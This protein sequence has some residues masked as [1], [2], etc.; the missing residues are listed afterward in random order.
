MEFSEPTLAIDRTS[1]RAAV[2]QMMTEFVPTHFLTF[3]FNSDVSVASADAELR[4]FKQWL[5]RAMTGKRNCDGSALEHIATI[6]H[7]ATNLHIHA[8]F[9]VPNEW[10]QRFEQQAPRVWEKLRN[11]GSL[12]I[13]SVYSAAGVADYITKEM[14]P[15]ASHRLLV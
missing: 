4:K 3:A 9:R 7:E 8:V 11:A 13:Q 10:Q 2:I 14:K 12:N 6:E 1:Y 15:N 5:F